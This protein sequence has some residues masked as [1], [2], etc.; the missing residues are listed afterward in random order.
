MPAAPAVI[1]RLP[2]QPGVY[3]F[4]DAGGRVLYIGRAIRLRR[5]VR[6]YWRD[7]KDRQHLARMVTQVTRIE[8]VVCASDHEACWLERNLLDRSRPR[9]NRTIGGAEVPI[10]IV[11][12]TE[13]PR[14]RLL[15]ET[16]FPPDGELIFGPFL[17][18]LKVRLLAAALGRIYP[19]GYTA[20]R[21]S[22]TER[23]LGRIRGVG[24]ADRDSMINTVGAVLARDPAEVR[25][26]LAQLADRRDTASRRHAYETAGQLQAELAASQWLLAIQRVTIRPA[27]T[28]PI[29]LYGWHAG[30]LVAFRLQDGRISSWQIR[31]CTERLAEPR[32]ASTP[33]AWRA[34]TDENARLAATLRTELPS[35][36]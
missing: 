27:G 7:L 12:D 10:M 28:D 13:P 14:L 2:E 30:V 5:R 35:S 29:D 21:L 33:D 1:S 16:G 6:S 36:R 25:S 26:F 8:A 15:H 18:G 24:V 34:F 3:R 31:D 11:I 17:G 32:V 19:I 23:D 22:G 4:R 20:D 9:W